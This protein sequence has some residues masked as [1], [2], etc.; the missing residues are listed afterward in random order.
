[1]QYDADLPARFKVIE[2][3]FKECNSYITNELHSQTID[4]YFPPT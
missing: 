3:H 1:M 4:L 2:T